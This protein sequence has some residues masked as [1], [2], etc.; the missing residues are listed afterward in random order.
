MKKLF[1]FF[2]ILFSLPDIL[3]QS[4]E[5]QIKT[6][7]ELYSSGK[8]EDAIATYEKALSAKNLQKDSSYLKLI[9]QLAWAY[10]DQG[11]YR[12]AETLFTEIKSTREKSGKNS[13]DY[14]YACSCLSLVYYY[15]GQ[16]AKAEPLCIEAKNIRERVLGKEHNSYANS[17]INLADIYAA[18]SLFARAETLYMEAKNI[19]EKVQGNQSLDYKRAANA[20]AD[21]YYD[22]GQYNKAE[23][24]YTEVKNISEKIYGK[25][26]PAYARACHNLAILYLDNGQ[27]TKA[28]LLFVESKNIIGKAYGTTDPDYA[29]SCNSLANV[30]YEQGLYS[31][32]EPLYI[33]V[34][35]IFEKAYGKDNAD[36]AMAC[37]NLG[38]LYR[39]Q[40]KLD[41]AELLYVEAKNI[42]EKVLGKGHPEYATSCNN[43]ASVYAAEGL[44]EKAEPLFI[45][46]KNIH[47]KVYGK[48]HP[49]YALS[50]NNL[51]TLYLDQSDYAKSEASYLEAKNIR[52]K[53]FGKLHP[54]YAASCNSLAN[55]YTDEGL[56]SKAEPLYIEAKNIQEKMLGKDHPKYA[57]SCNNLANLYFE[58]KLYDKAALLHEESRAIQEKALGKQHPAYAMS[59]NNLGSDYYKQGQYEKAE[60]L[61]L[62]A[63]SIQE[64]F[65]GKDHPDYALSCH[66]LASIYRIQGQY[67][68]S[69]SFYIESKNIWER[70]YGKDHKEYANACNNLANL[71]VAQK[72]HSKAGPLY[73]EAINNKQKQISEDLPAM[74]EREREEFYRSIDYYFKRYYQFVLLAN[75]PALYS[76]LF[77][78]QLQIKGLI[79][80]STQRMQKQIINSG[81]A[82][83]IRKYEN[84]KLQKA[85]LVR[86]MMLPVA[87]RMQKGINT[88]SLVTLINDLERSLSVQS[89]AF[90]TV[91]RKQKYTWLDVQ[92]KLLPGEAAV[93]IIR[94]DSAYIALI[95]KKTTTGNPEAVILS[96]GAELDKRYIRYYRNSIAHK[97]EDEYSYN[98]FWLPIREKLKDVSKVYLC[99]D[100]VYHQLNL[101]TLKNPSTKSYL[102]NEVNIQLVSNLRDLLSMQK[103]ELTTQYEKYKVHLIAYPQYDGGGTGK[104]E[105]SSPNEKI[106][107]DTSQRFFD[108]GG[109]IT[110]L[111][112]TKTEAGNIATICAQANHTTEMKLLGDASESYLKSLTNPGILHIATHGFFM[113]SEEA[114]ANSRGLSDEEYKYTRDPLLNSGLLLA[115]AQQGLSGQ[116][117]NE[118]DGVL[119]AKE[120]LNL[121][122]DKTSL[123]V[124]SACETGLGE[125]RN[126]EGVYGLQRAFQQAGAKTVIISLWKVSDEATQELMSSFYENLLGKKMN[127]RKA[128][129]LA[130]NSLMQKYPDPYYW[131]AFVM[132]G[133]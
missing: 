41:K 129:L 21:T 37:N 15:Q 127:K 90:A 99:Q 5:D 126:G 60:P 33:E 94:T 51:G 102:L 56:Y 122:L 66:N 82:E 105:F 39:E 70:T 45:E 53:V 78:L 73:K 91:S 10:V 115:N 40:G 83:L 132:I 95:V 104:K 88:D 13:A 118:E 68:K 48:N 128:F 8:Y 59:C 24:L 61:F 34:K 116:F 7:D 72:N 112:G 96:N 89:E 47:E 131:G 46:A 11:T 57:T 62:E 120:A 123:V 14:A 125:I 110:M 76:D 2:I 69:E 6:G 65:P 17:C 3:A 81:N 27:Y 38:G 114:T 80:Q 32:A 31:K 93:E 108:R 44:Y 98:N 12:K 1:L 42:R 101:L 85:T 50:C 103:D 4:I 100:G 74:S 75:Q 67:S 20:L 49:R 55:L 109:K 107:S 79:F 87:V 92:K 130:Q 119:T 71:Y 18:Q 84:W 26:D 29:N 9:H 64:K 133:E 54:D 19:F 22:M 25:E 35:N 86:Y 63:R 106:K 124:M 97:M 121:T 36:Y 16:Y 28:E 23:P 117:M 43:V 77:N 58:Q 52:E 113:S 111:A 30:Y